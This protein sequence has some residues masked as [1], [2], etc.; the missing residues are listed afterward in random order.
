MNPA[1]ILFTSSVRDIASRT[2]V[3]RSVV[4]RAM[5]SL[6]L[7]ATLAGC[8]SG[9]GS[10]P[11]SFSGWQGHVQAYVADQG[12]GDMNALREVLV[13]PGQPGFRSYSNDRPEDS[14]DIV[15]VL[16]GAY[17]HA[18]RIWYVYLVGEVNKEQVTTIRLAAVSF[19]DGQFAWRHGD[20]ENDATAAYRRHRE[21]AWRAAHGSGEIPPVA[22]NFPG[23]AD[24][25]TM[26]A[27]GDALTV[28]ES[29]SG[30]QWTLDLVDHATARK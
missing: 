22:L 13:A 6:A 24:Q 4:A 2:T 21:Q 23:V 5:L 30:A 15:G 12:N 27:A 3:S 28:R 29:E 7:M 8:N 9:S 17:P 16:V 10:R 19:A 1:K 25:F 14:K 26:Q 11:V 20:D 18:D